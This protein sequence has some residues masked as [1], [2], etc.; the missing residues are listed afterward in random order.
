MR[1]VVR[2]S[3]GEISIFTAITRLRKRLNIGL[4][5]SWNKPCDGFSHGR[6]KTLYP[7]GFYKEWRALAAGGCAKTA[8]YCLGMRSAH[9]VDKLQ[10]YIDPGRRENHAVRRAVA[11]EIS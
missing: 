4:V 9:E 10:T 1:W 11:D 3:D 8:V 5:G 7:H 2:L 6:G